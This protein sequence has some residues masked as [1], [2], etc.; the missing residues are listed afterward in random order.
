MKRL[1]FA[2][3]V[4]AISASTY[5]GATRCT[6]AHI[7]IKSSKAHYAKVAGKLY[8]K[9]IAV[10]TNKCADSVGVQVK[11]TSYA[12]D[13][14]PVSTHE[15]WPA[16]ISNIAPGDYTFT[17]DFFLDY[18]KEAKTFDVTVSRVNRW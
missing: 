16:S 4:L 1:L 5:A 13:G 8:M 6:V 3:A 7:T 18:D 2:C 15:S 9:G 11:M 17:L 12:K 10:L 14:S